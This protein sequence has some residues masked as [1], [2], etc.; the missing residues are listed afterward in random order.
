M[1][2][3]LAKNLIIFLSSALL[4]VLIVKMSVAKGDPRSDENGKV[5]ETPISMA[6]GS[7]VSGE[8]HLSLDQ[9]VVR[10]LRGLAGKKIPNQGEMV[11]VKE[12]K[13]G[14]LLGRKLFWIS[15]SDSQS[16]RL[17]YWVTAEVMVVRPVVVST[18]KIKRNHII[19]WSDLTVKSFSGSKPVDSFILDPEEAVGKRVRRS[20][21]KGAPV[22]RDQIEEAPVIKQGDQVIILVEGGGLKITSIGR[23]KEDGYLG[24]LVAV[25]N[26][27]SRKT[28]YG[29]V[30]DHDRVRVKIAR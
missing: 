5:L 15:W 2:L 14:R 4:V 25:V 17:E 26:L 21:K 20:I 16:K 6:I 11:Y 19:Q 27:D 28:V 24:R 13:T 3:K 22:I 12:G 9:V 23:A 7:Y 8:L 1:R 30:E 10:I 29:V 18:K